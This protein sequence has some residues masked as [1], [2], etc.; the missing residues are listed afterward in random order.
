MTTA[1]RRTLSAAT[2]TGDKVFNL[3]GEELGYLKDIMLDLETGHIAYAVMSFGGF[4][5]MG[6]KL[7]AVPWRSL[8]LRAE[9]HSFILDANRE[10]LEAAEGFDKDN[11]PDMADREW[12]LRMHEYYGV[13]PYWD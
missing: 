13:R 10:R 9:D 1:T 8:E 11:W 5:G 2:L 7:F 4:L 12:G 3:G 6:D